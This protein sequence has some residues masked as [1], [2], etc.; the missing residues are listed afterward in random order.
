MD[1]KSIID[2]AREVI[3]KSVNSSPPRPI[4]NEIA[5][6]VFKRWKFE[7]EKYPGWIVAP[8]GKRLTVWHQ[9]KEWSRVLPQYA[10]E[11]T[12]ADRI[13][14]FRELNW[15]LELSMV[16]LFP[17]QI[18]PFKQTVSELFEDFSDA[19]KPNISDWLE[20]S[21]VVSYSELLPS[22][23]EVALALLREARESYD[24]ENWNKMY[25]LIN[26]LASNDEQYIDRLRY[27]KALW[28]MWNV[29]RESARTIL[30]SWQPSAAKPFATI[31]KSGLLAEL[32]DT[33]EARDLLKRSLL[34]I[35]NAQQISGQD[36]EL[37]SLEGW[38]TYLLNAI[39]SSI[40][41]SSEASRQY[42]ERWQ[43]LKAWDCN[44]WLIKESFDKA[45]SGTPPI[46]PGTV[47]LV[48]EFDPG[49][50]SI[51]HHFG[52]V[53][54][55]LPAF[56]YIR[57]FEQAGIPLRISYFNIAGPALESACHWIESFIDFWS[58]ALLIRAESLANLS[59][60]DQFLSRP[61][62]AQ[63]KEELVPKLFD[64]CIRIWDREAKN[65]SIERPCPADQ[66][67]C[68][69]VEVI[70]RLSVRLDQSQLQA[71]FDRLVTV[72]PSC[73]HPGLSLT[74]VCRDWLK[75]L[76][77]AAEPNSLLEWLPI[78]I[79]LPIDATENAYDEFDV[80]EAFPSRRVR[81]FDVNSKLRS[82]IKA[83]IDWLLKNSE[84]DAR[85]AI[86]RLTRLHEAGLVTKSQQKDFANLLW[87]RQGDGDYLC[88]S[89]LPWSTLLT[90]P[91]LQ[92][93]DGIAL[94]KSK[95]LDVSGASDQ[96][97]SDF[98]PKFLIQ[99]AHTTK[100]ILGVMGE[101]TGAIEWSE[102]EALELFHRTKDWWREIK[103]KYKEESQSLL[104]HQ[105]N[106]SRVG[107][108]LAQFL[109]RVMLPKLKLDIPVSQ[110]L[111]NW[112]SELKYVGVY[113]YQAFP[114]AIAEQVVLAEELSKQ[115]ELGLHGDDEDEVESAADAVR[116]HAV[117]HNAG[118]VSPSPAELVT[119]LINRVA[120]RRRAGLTA[121]I[122]R[123]TQLLAQSTKEVNVHQMNMLVSSL[124]PWLEQLSLHEPYGEFTPAKRPGL[125]RS[126]AHLAGLLSVLY[127]KEDDDFGAIE[128]WRENSESDPLPEV[129]RAFREGVELLRELQE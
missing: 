119:L 114:Y 43:A 122:I 14:F 15:R 99:A 74:S 69:L 84:S 89:L 45:L 9:T 83:S 48:Q 94:V 44:P 19:R 116:H 3:P 91:S 87:K 95:I 97:D 32:G 42:R 96:L 37:F 4:S 12:S 106:K 28:A 27:E 78:L 65:V 124:V 22:W 112:F 72:L 76:F 93:I 108:V 41:Y 2:S 62:L 90:L 6:S 85:R 75:R 64:W 55:Y 58:P 29:D 123:C 40:D 82:S 120:L 68:S 77:N 38:C 34:E 59:K 18:I 57:F 107:K 81:N 13:L 92:D 126:L 26:E 54:P 50:E 21:G 128:Q 86:I 102:E 10:S 63:M 31:W 33:G 24:S 1:R 56:S 129:R 52:D 80:F 104:F 110:E 20:E 35:R 7:R 117:L 115:I 105:V 103:H 113:V 53:D 118:I 36:I 8:E 98:L 47:T 11:W 100:P 17:D 23:I 67:L 39:E 109:S 79:R 60:E 125:K 30:Y 61:C 101:T 121:C 73:K 49:Q 88:F 70:S 25:E 66:L 111:I 46:P 127:N 51:R 71:S 16:P 5:I